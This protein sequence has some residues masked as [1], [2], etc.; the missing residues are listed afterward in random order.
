MFGRT[1]RATRSWPEPGNPMRARLQRSILGLAYFALQVPLQAQVSPVG[2]EFQVNSYGVGSQQDS[3]VEFDAAGNF[4]VVWN[5]RYIS[6]HGD[7]MDSPMERKFSS[8]GQPLASELQ[9]DFTSLYGTARFALQ[10]GG[11]FVIVRMNQTYWQTDSDI[12]AVLYDNQGH[13]T[14]AF[15]AN[16]LSEP[17]NYCLTPSVAAT[18][19][20]GFIVVWEKLGW[21][22]TGDPSPSIYMRQFGAGGVPS[23][24]DFKVNTHTTGVQR[25]PKVAVQPDGDF[26]VVWQSEGPTEDDASGLGIRARLFDS[27]GAPAS[28]EFQVNSFT[29]DDQLAPD[30]ATFADGGFVIAWQSEGS[31][32]SDSSE[33]SVQARLFSSL[34]A[35]LGEQFQVN[36]YS[37][38]NQREP[39]VAA[40]STGTFAV[41][42][43]SEG[44]IGSDESDTSVQVRR[45]RAD[46]R[47]LT[48]EF[49]VNTY[50]TNRQESPAIAF[51]PNGDFV[52]TW[53][54][55]GSTGLDNSETSIQARQFQGLFADGFDGGSMLRWRS[56]ID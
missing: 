48:N 29:L 31:L 40:D 44:S 37:T 27:F 14:T 50:T 33:L 25:A 54:S 3:A 55:V 20:A 38:W 19:H 10:P 53:E 9:L 16:S 24:G 18:P 6:H 41:T 2:P 56:E 34:G 49:Q 52:V 43:T 45:Y 21:G 4:V 26:V 36:S 42:W 39:A 51:S 46:G 47:A 30:V 5:N 12:R 15:Q 8:A 7:P 13:L 11:E 32:G 35:P 17:Y 28:D 22:S 23:E 1:N